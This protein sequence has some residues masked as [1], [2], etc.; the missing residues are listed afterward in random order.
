VI[1]CAYLQD[2]IRPKLRSVLADFGQKVLA[3][4]PQVFK[5]DVAG[6][7]CEGPPFV[8]YILPH[9]AVNGIFLLPP[10]PISVNSTTS[11][12]LDG[13]SG[14][15]FL[16]VDWRD[17]FVDLHHMFDQSGQ[18]H[19]GLWLAAAVVLLLIWLFA[20]PLLLRNVAVYDLVAYYT[21]LPAQYNMG[22]VGM[23]YF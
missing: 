14:N 21:F 15:T 13:L 4:L 3:V 18:A 16:A 12:G 6:V 11:E 23:Y 19:L 17:A 1:P 2:D 22:T 7:A 8:A 9:Y 20:M 5:L 10:L